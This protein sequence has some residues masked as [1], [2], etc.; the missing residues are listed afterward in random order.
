MKDQHEDPAGI[1][2]PS[3]V[4]AVAVC[5]VLRCV[6]ASTRSARGGSSG[7]RSAVCHGGACPGR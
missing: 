5:S 7:A 6:W 2:H 1:N 4:L 3:V